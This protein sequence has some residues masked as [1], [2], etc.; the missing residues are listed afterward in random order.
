ME[1]LLVGPAP[2]TSAPL[3]ALV[4]ARAAAVHADFVTVLEVVLARGA[5]VRLNIEKSPSRYS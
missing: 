4:I 1:G 2:R 3:T 5:P